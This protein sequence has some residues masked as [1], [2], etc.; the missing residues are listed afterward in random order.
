MP[1]MLLLNRPITLNTVSFTFYL[2]A[3]VLIP[4][5]D[6]YF[7]KVGNF[8][9]TVGD[10]FVM[11][12]LIFMAPNF[13][14]TKTHAKLLLVCLL[15]FILTNLGGIMI[16]WSSSISRKYFL[17]FNLAWSFALIILA[18]TLFHLSSINIL[19]RIKHILV[20]IYLAL[21]MNSIPAM[22][23]FFTHTEI[24]WAYD[25][26]G[27]RYVG[28]SVQANQYVSFLVVYLMLFILIG[29]KFFRRHLFF[30]FI[31]LLPLAPSVLFSGS[32]T[33]TFGY[34]ISLM[35][36]LFFIFLYSSPVKKFVIIISLYI[37]VPLTINFFLNQLSLDG[38]AQIE[39]A[40]TITNL[41]K[42]ESML[43]SE[44]S[45]SQSIKHGIK[46]F[47]ANPIFGVGLAQVPFL[48]KIEVHNTYVFLLSETGLVG[49]LGFCLILLIIMLSIF[50]SKTD[51]SFKL[52]LII[53][54]MIFA[55]MNIPHLLLRQRW[56][57]FFIG[58]IFVLCYRKR[59]GSF[60]ASQLNLLNN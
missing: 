49:F 42:V 17:R 45:T 2:L 30:M 56:V 18:L 55:A 33:G 26:A 50:F 14:L 28:F 35:I 12:S 36:I 5:L 1:S 59:D 13:K 60:A 11:L 51:I 47:K 48:E 31:L 6:L 10:S 16:D 38:G 46:H 24:P 52:I 15:F 29:T 39:R 43:T 37:I 22:F 21:L 54:L 7:F 4:A 32:R 53:F 41:E 40:L 23:Q 19:K 25:V 20:S 8:E 44:T 58:V 34:F 3:I 27:W 57:W 9:F